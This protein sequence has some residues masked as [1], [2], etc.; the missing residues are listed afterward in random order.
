MTTSHDDPAH[1]R[2]RAAEARRVAEGLSSPQ[3]RVHMLECARAYDRLAVLAER[4]A[5]SRAG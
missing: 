4:A 1:W 3:A 5:A 2:K